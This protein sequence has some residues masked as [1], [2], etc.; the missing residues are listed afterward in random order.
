MNQKEQLLEE[1]AN[2]E[3]QQWREWAIQIMMTE[4]ISEERK[5][6]WIPLCASSYYEL[7]EEQKEQDRVWARQVLRI[8]E[9]KKT[10]SQR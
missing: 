3:H 6:R 2:L 9:A 5:K 1:L 10:E 7:T 4:L 8:V